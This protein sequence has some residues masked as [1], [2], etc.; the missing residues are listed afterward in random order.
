MS[1][2]PAER[3]D[4]TRVRIIEAAERLFAI[5][6]IDGV[7][8]RQIVQAA[9]QRNN[10]AVT[11]HF[12]STRA[13]V[14]A[15]L[16]HRSADVDAHR[17]ALL[18]ALNEQRGILT[19]DDVAVATMAPLVHYM[20]VHAP[21]HYLR[22]MQAVLQWVG[23][24]RLGAALFLPPGLRTVARRGLALLDF[25]PLLGRRRR[26]LMVFE[27]CVQQLALLEARQDNPD[28]ASLADAAEEILQAATRMLTMPA[29]AGGGR[30]RDLLIRP[31]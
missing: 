18:A 17:V 11:Y 25:L 9:G 24:R 14:L 31:R 29:P 15:I 22:F 28:A 1:T 8:T 27:Y 16:R 19:L 12:G 5:H 7:S 6:G 4:D 26:L 21:S 23:P 2:S 13:L 10:S 30:L 20:D 3:A